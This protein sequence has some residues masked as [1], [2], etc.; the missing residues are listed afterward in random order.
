VSFADS[1][2]YTREPF[3]QNNILH[4]VFVCFLFI[5]RASIE[6]RDYR[7]VFVIQRSAEPRRL[8][9]FKI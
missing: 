7:V 1:S 5:G 2:L 9:A 3:T 6:P 8:C 4:L